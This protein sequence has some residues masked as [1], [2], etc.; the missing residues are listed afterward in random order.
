MQH[1]LTVLADTGNITLAAQAI[2]TSTQTL[3]QW[4]NKSEA[5]KPGYAVVVD[6]LGDE[7]DVPFH[8]AWEAARRVSLHLVESEQVRLATGYDDPIVFGG[9]LAYAQDTSQ[10]Y[11][12][13]AATG[14]A[15]WP[16]KLDPITGEPQVLTVRK[17]SEKAGQFILKARH[18]GYKDKAELDVTSGGKPLLVGDAEAMTPEKF[19]AR[20][21]RTVDEK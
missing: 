16:P 11:K 3:Q 9:K 21:G 4:Y 2:G 8:E 14:M 17:V 12:V 18:P 13:D 6:P 1:F 19:M 15:Y 10:G 7:P 20:F 5:G